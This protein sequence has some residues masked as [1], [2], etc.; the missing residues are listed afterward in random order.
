MASNPM[1][2][3]PHLS[4]WGL[5]R[6]DQPSG[7]AGWVRLLPLPAGPAPAAVQ[8]R[9]WPELCPASTPSGRCRVPPRLPPHLGLA[10]PRTPCEALQGSWEAPGEPE[11]LPA[12]ALHRGPSAV[13]RREESWR[14]HWNRQ[15]G[16][17]R[18]QSGAAGAESEVRACTL[19]P[20]CPFLV[21][22]FPRPISVSLHLL[23]GHMQGVPTGCPFPTV[24]PRA[25]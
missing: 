3:F 13:V 22:V 5:L 6:R 11:H 24:R 16:A 1:P 17:G 7:E 25:G 10:L 18:S 14:G 12:A 21:S 2:Q 19:C 20:S 15:A 4:R 23:P 9:F 8:K